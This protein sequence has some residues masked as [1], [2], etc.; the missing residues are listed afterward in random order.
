MPIVDPVIQQHAAPRAN[1]T[2]CG[3][4]ARAPRRWL[5]AC[6]HRQTSV[7]CSKAGLSIDMACAGNR[8]PTMY[9]STVHIDDRSQKHLTI[10]KRIKTTQ[11]KEAQLCYFQHRGPKQKRNRKQKQNITK[12]QSNKQETETTH[13]QTEGGTYGR[14]RG[15]VKC[16]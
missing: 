11:T 12:A 15:S 5:F 13:Q 9:T 2:V 3:P 16:C 6:M 14:C 1:A 4:V 8:S 10:G 7:E